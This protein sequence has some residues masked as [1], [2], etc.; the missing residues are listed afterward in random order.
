MKSGASASDNSP[1]AM[2]VPPGNSFFARSGSTWIHCSS[3][4]ASA[5]WLIL[6]CET[7]IQSLVPISV[8]R[9]DLISL[10]SLNIRTFATSSDIHFRDD[11]GDQ[12]FGFGYRQNF[13]DADAW[14]GFQ[15]GRL[16]VRKSNDSHIRHDQTHRP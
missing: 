4:V 16:P 13:G 10:K 2:V 9:A 1:W 8:P 14:R 3:H 6:S 12:E 11:V 7:S 15:Q 5:N